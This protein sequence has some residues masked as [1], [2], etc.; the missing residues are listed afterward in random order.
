MIIE[1]KPTQA[2]IAPAST[3][4]AK[5]SSH[6]VEMAK[7]GYHAFVD[8]AFGPGTPDSR[9]YNQAA[10]VVSTAAIGAGLW[11]SP[12][13]TA[14]GV[15]WLP[16]LVSSDSISAG[17]SNYRTFITRLTASGALAGV[18]GAVGLMSGIGTGLAAVGFA[19]LVIADFRD[20]FFR[21]HGANGS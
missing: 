19:P 10:T 12:I 4:I 8:D 18:L 2:T 15:A 3:P 7:T 17:P 13:V 20:A 9:I 16:G 21:S 14:L 5:A 6:L 11:L 1:N